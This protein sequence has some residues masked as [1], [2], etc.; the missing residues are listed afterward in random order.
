M[1]NQPDKQSQSNLPIPVT[2]DE[3]AEIAVEAYLFAYPAVLLDITRRVLTNTEAPG[4]VRAPM[5][6]FAHVRAFPDHTFTEVIRP[7]ADTLYSSLFFDVEREPLVISVPDSSGRY[8]L[9]PILDLWTDVFACP[10]AR[11]TGTGAQTLA[12]A[13]PE[14]EGKLPDD[15]ELIRAPTNVGWMIGRVQT[16]GKADFAEV[17]KF[18]D[19]LTATPLGGLG[20]A[21][22]PPKGNLDPSRDMSAPG[23]QTANMDAATF[24]TLFAGLMQKN[25][26]HF[27]DYPILARM[28][29]IGI[30]PGQPFDFA[31]LSAQTQQALEKAPETAQKRLATQWQQLGVRANNW[32]MMNSPVGTYGADY[33]RRAVIAFGALG[34]NVLDDAIYPTSLTDADGH[35]YDSSKKYVM[36]FPKGELPPIRAFW[37]LTMYNDRQFFAANPIDRYAVGDRD[38]LRLDD[39]GSLTLYIQRESP[40]IDKETNWLPAPQEGEF[41]MNLRLYWPKSEAI[42][43]TW[44]PAEVVE[45]K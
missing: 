31:Q 10:G 40:G 34:A 37:S 3:A 45:V 26:P 12:I 5:N 23:E 24:F 17:H 18:Q 9:L 7:N 27:N 39:D 21:Y 4:G 35:P 29:R 11:T 8:Y 6:Q 2:H 44:K 1:T 14:W 15:V 42:D 22:T 13:G 32:Q 41:S 30:E 25:R 28:R 20:R 33:L 19:A 38:N 36:R 43:F 16:N